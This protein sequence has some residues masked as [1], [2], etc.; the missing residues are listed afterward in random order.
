[1][2]RIENKVVLI[3]YPDSLGGNLKSLKENI[4]TF[5]PKAIGGI[6]ILPFY[7]SSGDRGFAVI[8]YDKVDPTW[9]TWD[10]MDKLAEQ[11][12][13]IADFMLNHISIRSK[14]FMDYME[15]GDTSEYRDL[16]VDWDR[17]WP[18]GR[19]TE[20][21]LNMLYRR[22]ANA[23]Y[24][25]F[26]RSDGKKVKL[27]NTFFEEQ[28]DINP[29]SDAAKRYFSRNLGKISEHVPMIRFDA[30]AYTSK[31]PGTSCFF[32]EPEIWEILDTAMEPLK[33][34]HTEMLAEIHENYH[35]QEKMAMHGYWVYDFALPLLLLHAIYTGKTHELYNW[36]KICPRKQFT[37][38]DTHDGI[39]VIDVTGLLSEEEIDLTI[40]LAD[41]KT[42]DIKKQFNIPNMLKRTGGKTQRYQLAGTYY[43][44]LGCDDD[45]YL[46]ARAV[47]FFA[48]GIP[49]VYYVGL[50]AGEN[51]LEAVKNGA[52][53]R[54]MN[55]HNYTKKEIEK[56]MRREVVS[57]LIELCRFRNEYTVFD[58]RYTILET[59]PGELFMKWEKNGLKAELTADF[60]NRNFNI[61]YV[62]ISTNFEKK[63]LL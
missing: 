25:E 45:S 2:K 20:D 23:P 44:L 40:H 57:K 28:I 4:N 56:N 14:E 49:M 32:V 10:D 17:F 13:L 42:A 7:P 34:T 61:T 22:K 9:G 55:R 1:M 46:L 6:H 59:K 11:Y 36:F 41:Q 47:Q 63:L 31:K 18:A 3:T 12:A 29:Y 30:F 35:L 21:D 24:Q 8:E 62:D 27:W 37:T 33:R 52:E 16:F 15:N 39:G 48:P 5:F 54:A 60:V 38:L 26:I 51:D 43:S 50:L 53:P 19:P 58:G